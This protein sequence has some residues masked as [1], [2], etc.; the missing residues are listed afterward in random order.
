MLRERL[1]AGA[2]AQALTDADYRRMTDA[3]LRVRAAQRALQ[4]VELSRAS[5]EVVARERE[6]LTAALADLQR[7][8]G[9]PPSQLIETIDA[10]SGLSHDPLPGESGAA[11]D[12]EIVN[13]P[14]GNYPP[15]R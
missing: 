14:L 4:T 10:D 3:V 2:A 12:E 11:A 1:A 8:S 13:E 5:A 9:I 7:A 6:Q 15:R